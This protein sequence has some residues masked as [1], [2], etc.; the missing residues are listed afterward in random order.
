MTQQDVIK[1]DI[2]K[3][4]Q[5]KQFLAILILLFVAL[6]FWIII[7]LISSQTTEKISPE[8][9]K[10]A[11]PLTPVIDTQVFEKITA[12]RQ[13]SNEELSSFTIYKVLVSKDGRTERVVPLEVTADDL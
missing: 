10:L 13:Y 4:Q 11:K 5:S 6:L 3:L 2:K 8:L 12:K 1:R 9:Q 7:S